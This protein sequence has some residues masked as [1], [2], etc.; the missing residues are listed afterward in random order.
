MLHKITKVIEVLRRVLRKCLGLQESK[1]T[2]G[3]DDDLHGE[4]DRFS[5][6]LF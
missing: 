4:D 5:Y 1:N 2:E 3:K 6:P